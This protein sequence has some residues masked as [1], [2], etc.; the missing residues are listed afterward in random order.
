MNI[1]KAQSILKG[2]E[3]TRF[4]ELQLALFDAAMRYAT[5]RSEYALADAEAR[6]DLEDSR[7]RAHD[8]FIDSCNILSRNMASREE[9]NSWRA[10]AGNDR[11][12]LGDLA[13]FI[14]L[15]LALKVR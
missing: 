12:E 11:R 2:V 8:A 9:D 14:Q 6:S 3:Q 5:L 15:L 13:C 4:S 1:D 10:T 7:T